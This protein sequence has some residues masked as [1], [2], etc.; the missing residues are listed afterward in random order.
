MSARIY[1][2]AKTAMQS[3]RGKTKAW[4]LDFDPKDAQ[5]ADP[6]MG[7]CGSGDTGRQISL[8]FHTQDDALAYAKRRG[9]DCI[10]VQ[11]H[12]PTPK[13]KAYADNFR[14]DRTR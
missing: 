8:G 2:P 5:R 11:P 13:P 12:S 7:W 9:I 14:Y 4:V 10:V 1:M 6:L 3:G